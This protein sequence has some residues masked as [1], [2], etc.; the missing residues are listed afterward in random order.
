MIR[1]PRRHQVD[2]SSCL[3]E[4]PFLSL[5]F[6]CFLLCCQHSACIFIVALGFHCVMT[7]GSL[8]P[9]QIWSPDLPAKHAHVVTPQT[10]ASSCPK[11]KSSDSSHKD[12]DALVFQH[13][14]LH[15]YYP[16]IPQTL[17]FNCHLLMRDMSWCFC[18]FEHLPL[19]AKDILSIDSI[20]GESKV[21]WVLSTSFLQT[22]IP[23]PKGV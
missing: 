19:F 13:R 3:P 22:C 23:T 2:P 11:S 12:G 20:S 15:F 10:L 21:R 1:C 8:P 16:S 5:W 9:A 7:P 18:L 6:V 17:I 14:K 4:R